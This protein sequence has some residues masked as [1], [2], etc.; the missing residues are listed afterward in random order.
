MVLSLDLLPS[1]PTGKN[2]PTTGLRG[3]HHLFTSFIYFQCAEMVYE[4]NVQHRL[5]WAADTSK[6]SKG[7]FK[8]S[9]W[10][11][12]PRNSARLLV[13]NWH[14]AVNENDVGGKALSPRDASPGFLPGTWSWVRGWRTETAER[15][16]GEALEN[17]VC[18]ERGCLNIRGTTYRFSPSPGWFLPVATLTPSSSPQGSFFSPP[19]R[20][21]PCLLL[22]LKN[23][24]IHSIE[25]QGP[26]SLYPSSL[27][28]S[29][30]SPRH[31]LF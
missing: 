9:L 18:V 1:D 16:Q 12:G 25:F 19:K 11:I 24:I 8:S 30:G 10:E 23:P 29:P 6:L 13:G 3:H 22:N 26:R 28:S 4:W 7:W 31:P 15:L 20:R 5:S 14:R 17:G 27:S 21:H 2:I